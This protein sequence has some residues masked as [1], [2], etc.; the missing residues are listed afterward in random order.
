MTDFMKHVSFLVLGILLLF[1][2]ATAQ[3]LPT[4]STG[5]DWVNSGYWTLT[6][7]TT[8]GGGEATFILAME[9]AAYESNFGLY[10]VDN[11]N[12]PES[13]LRFQVFAAGQEPGGAL[14]PTQQ[15]VFFQDT[16]GGWRI[17]LD[18]SHWSGFGDTFGFYFQVLN[19]GQIYYSD[20]RLNST[21]AEQV[22]DHVLTTFNSTNGA[23]VYLEDL[24]GLGDRDF[25][26]MVIQGIDIAPAPVP[27]PAT[28]VLLGI[29]L[30]GIVGLRCR[31]TNLKK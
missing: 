13:P 28:L 6:D 2:V 31:K 9:R 3:A 17:S 21:A 30:L 22:N 8:C 10:T 5:Y 1:S 11:R 4:P 20:S 25:E 18:N 27:E 24:P 26:D 19:T 29:G 16:A 15:S 23:F 14:S 7:T 12:E